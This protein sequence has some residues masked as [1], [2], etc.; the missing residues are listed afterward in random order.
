MGDFVDLSEHLRFVRLV[1]FNQ[2]FEDRFL[3]VERGM[4]IDELKALILKNFFD[5]LDLVISDA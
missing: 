5:S 4:Q 3:L 2:R 1:R